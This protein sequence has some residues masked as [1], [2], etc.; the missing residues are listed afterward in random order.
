MGR[1]GFA[2]RA[3][4]L[5]RDSD[6]TI[7][8]D[9]DRQPKTRAQ[10]ARFTFEVR[11]TGDFVVERYMR[12]KMNLEDYKDVFEPFERLVRIEICGR[13]FDVPENNSV[14]RCLQYLSIET[15]SR[16]DLCWNGDCLNCQVW[17]DRGDG[18]EKGV[19]S[20]RTQIAE[21]MKIIRV[22]S[23]IESLLSAHLRAD[24]RA[25]ETE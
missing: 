25:G 19:I 15:V 10:A 1:G 20:C 14:L 9:K 22:T 12:F 4:F 5:M 8:T 6:A 2:V 7:L 3:I 24:G 21:G 18:R 16:G 23:E 13:E 11:A 17:I